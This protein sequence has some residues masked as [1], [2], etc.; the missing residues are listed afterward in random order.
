MSKRKI[1]YEH[2]TCAVESIPNLK[3]YESRK[4]FESLR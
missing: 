4:N 3:I 2:E 1:F